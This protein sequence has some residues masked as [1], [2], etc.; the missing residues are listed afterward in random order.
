[1]RKLRSHFFF[2]KDNFAKEMVVEQ[3]RPY[4]RVGSLCSGHQIGKIE[5]G[6]KAQSDEERRQ[7][8]G[9]TVLFALR[10]P[11]KRTSR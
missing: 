2:R 11:E 10:R 3:C 4:C 7:T 5:I 8:N 6:F 9:D 1:M